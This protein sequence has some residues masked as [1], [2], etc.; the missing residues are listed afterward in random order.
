[1]LVH[2]GEN[3]HRCFHR[4][5]VRQKSV[6]NG[7]YGPHLAVVHQLSRCRGDPGLLATSCLESAVLPGGSKE[8]RAP[9]TRSDLES[10]VFAVA[11]ALS[12]VSSRCRITTLHFLFQ[13][14]PSIACP[15]PTRI[16]H[17]KVFDSS[18]SHT[19]VN[20]T[21]GYQR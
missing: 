6:P 7:F 9:V 3:Y 1:M 5:C 18:N 10:S 11:I 14:D 12:L 8:G 2:G 20:T 15:S 4:E 19:Q 17:S 16:G 13:S 21:Q